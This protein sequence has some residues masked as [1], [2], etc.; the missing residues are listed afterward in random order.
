MIIHHDKV[1]FI[2]AMQA[3]FNIWESIKVIHFINKLKKKK[4]PHIIISLNA[5]KKHLT[6][7]NISSN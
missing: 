5:E 1:G 2:P 6:K 7:F 4:S 3:W